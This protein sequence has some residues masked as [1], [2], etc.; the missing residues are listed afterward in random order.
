MNK[1][2]CSKSNL[3]LLFLSEVMNC[4]KNFIDFLIMFDT[5]HYKVWENNES[6]CSDNRRFI[7]FF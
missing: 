5:V 3:H 4:F 7:L 1:K 6:I 2:M